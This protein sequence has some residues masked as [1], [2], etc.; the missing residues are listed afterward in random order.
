MKQ[1]AASGRKIGVEDL[2]PNIINKINW[3]PFSAVFFAQ[4]PFG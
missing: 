3:G 2:S 1:S 4:A